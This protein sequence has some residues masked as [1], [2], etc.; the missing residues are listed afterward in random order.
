MLRAS[1]MLSAADR[2]LG[3]FRLLHIKSLYSVKMEETPDLLS[4]LKINREHKAEA[5]YEMVLEEAGP[6]ATKCGFCSE[7]S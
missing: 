2:H 1:K 3:F 6:Q 5:I 4:C 7:L